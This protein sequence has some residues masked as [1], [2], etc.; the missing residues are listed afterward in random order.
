[1]LNRMM[2]RTSAIV[3][4]AMGLLASG[5]ASAVTVPFTESFDTGTENW[6]DAGGG[7]LTFV[8][9]GGADGGGY[10]ST[11]FD[12]STFNSPFGGG[13]ILF[14][15]TG[16]DNPSGGAF[17]G[18]W[19]G[20][21]VLSLTAN[22][23]HDSPV[24]LNFSTRLAPAL[25]TPGTN[26][27]SFAPVPGGVWTEL[28]FNVTVAPGL[29]VFERPGGCTLAGFQDVVN[30]QFSTTDPDGVGLVTLDLDEISLNPI[31]E[32][33]TALLMG[34]GLLGLGH[35]GRRNA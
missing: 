20:D 6:T 26:L 30:L 19:I 14:R 28:T 15:G 33:G 11:T 4:I 24:P 34:L 3:L 16:A 7:P 1:M 8:A 12:Y 31:P 23:R 2:I 10:V 9:S 21:G 22:V 13:P 25:N 5:T 29:C 17:I 18:D 27:I 35:A 32:P